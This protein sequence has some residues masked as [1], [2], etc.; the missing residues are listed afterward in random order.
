MSE[1]LTVNDDD[2][3]A[4]FL[5]RAARAREEDLLRSIFSA[6][7][8]TPQQR[9]WWRAFDWSAVGRTLAL[10]IVGALLIGL[11]LFAGGNNNPLPQTT[12]SP[13]AS[14]ASPPATA[15]S[16]PAASA[17]PSGAP[18]PRRASVFRLP[19]EYVIPVGTELERYMPDAFA[20]RFGE[21][22]PW[23]T[24]G[25]ATDAVLHGCPAG[26]GGSL[27]DEP[28]AFLSELDSAGVDLGPAQP[29]TLGGHP[30]LAADVE[31]VRCDFADMHLRGGLGDGELTFD[32]PSRL[33]VASVG[34]ELIVVQVAAETEE[35][36][37]ASLPIADELINS[38]EFSDAP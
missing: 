15:S 36:L 13:Q 23:V 6:T 14:A 31:G 1:R 21:G 16:P 26:S 19:F 28:G 29:T 10:A 17:S 5:R 12:E 8:A 4:V 24:V 9:R 30:A 3:R 35:S 38:I 27:S 34:G 25:W 32:R 11:A 33:I 22:A 7:S 20:F 18:R 37:A 2:I